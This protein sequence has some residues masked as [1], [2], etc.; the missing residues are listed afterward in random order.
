VP[1]AMIDAVLQA[2]MKSSRLPGKVML[3]VLG[4]PLLSLIIERLRRCRT[5]R[6]IV[7]ATSLNPADDVIATL[8]E[9]ERVGVF[10]G[11]E[12]DVLDRLYQCAR[13]AE[14]DSLAR[15]SADN[16][17]IDPWV[18]DRVIRL[19]LDRPAEFDFVSNNHP[20][21]WPDGLEVEVLRFAAL[22]R[23]WREAGEP[24][25]RE[26]GSPY[27][28][29]QPELFRLGNVSLENDDLYRRMRW[30]LDTPEDY[31][32]IKC[33]YEDLYVSNPAF[34]MADVLALLERKPEIYQINAHRGGEVWY[35]Q[36]MEKLRT[37]SNPK[38]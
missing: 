12:D 34:A 4:R 18:A 21:T 19:F 9:S 33:V 15:F 6:S 27:I 7:V 3:P 35:R 11:S 32:F 26:H 13:H 16:P 25:Q 5:V 17:L 31:E 10:R 20:P 29:D 38:Q 1:A 30:T 14:M 36:H 23:A 37:I 22:E 2:R 28:W 8:C 24:F